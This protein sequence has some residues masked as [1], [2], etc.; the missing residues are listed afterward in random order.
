MREDLLPGLELCKRSLYSIN[1][2]LTLL[3]SQE[4]SPLRSGA[5]LDHVNTRQSSYTCTHACR[6]SH[7]HT[8]TH[9]LHAIRSFLRKGFDENVYLLLHNI[10]PE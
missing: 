10:L 9:I 4:T 2:A 7:S 3:E 6:L 8:L 5:M 1:S